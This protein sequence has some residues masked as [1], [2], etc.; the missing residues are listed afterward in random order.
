MTEADDAPM[1]DDLTIGQLAE[2]LGVHYMTAYRYVRTGRFPA[3][4]QG[5][6]WRVRQSDIDAVL[7][8]DEPVPT[9]HITTR[10]PRQYVG[11]LTECLVI[12]D[13]PGAWR[14]TQDALATAYALE[15]LYLDVLS[16]AMSRVGDE[17]AAGRY[18]IAQEHRATTLM[19]RLV[20]R[21]GPG[22]IRSGPP[23]GTVIVGTPSGDHHGLATA[24]LADPLR[25]RR[26]R[27]V[28]LGAHTP[29]SSFAEA[30]TRDGRLVAI[31]IVSSTPVG[32]RVVVETIAAI[33]SQTTAPVLLGGHAI[34]DLR[35]ATELGADAWA[36]SNRDAIDWFASL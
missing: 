25:G 20:G 34:R 11:E 30:A 19:Y 36:N 12:G 26:F 9:T 35:H 21:L 27:V 24:L 7:R 29:A 23:R 15:G 28:D 14:V 31:G 4:K 16:A 2:L 32:D 13:E 8:A 1:Q 5:I 3:R 6:E 33:R 17:W 10:R 18:T 22:F